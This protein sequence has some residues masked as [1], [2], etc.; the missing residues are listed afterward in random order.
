MDTKIE[1]F[2]VLNEF[3]LNE[4]NGVYK[5][6]QVYDHKE[7]VTVVVAYSKANGGSHPTITTTVKEC[8]V[9]WYYV[10]KVEN[11]WMYMGGS[12]TRMNCLI[13]TKT[14]LGL[15]RG[16]LIIEMSTQSFSS[17]SINHLKT[18]QLHQN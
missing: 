15:A 6:G 10:V 7:K 5:C 3:N 13:S 17:I 12:S 18:S 11:S 1:D 16:V 9:G 2:L 8:K 4:R 14:T